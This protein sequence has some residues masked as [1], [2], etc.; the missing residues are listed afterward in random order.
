MPVI[1]VTRDNKSLGVITSGQTL[2]RA[3]INEAWTVNVW[4][5]KGEYPT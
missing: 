1:L 4:S 2:D 3:T 5:R